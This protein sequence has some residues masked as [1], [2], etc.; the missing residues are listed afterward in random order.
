MLPKTAVELATDALIQKEKLFALTEAETK[1]EEKQASL[2]SV[3]A[4][5]SILDL[6]EQTRQIELQL[7]TLN[8]TRSD[9]F[10]LGSVSNIDEK[11]AELKAQKE[12]KINEIDKLGDTE[13]RNELTA[14]TQGSQRRVLATNLHESALINAKK[15]IATDGARIFTDSASELAADARG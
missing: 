13:F 1:L 5:K 10:G 8:S 3:A 14:E 4:E 11:I 2:R 7:K 6:K 12:S 9:N 15:I